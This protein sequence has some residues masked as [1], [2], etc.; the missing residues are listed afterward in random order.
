MRE[1]RCLIAI[2]TGACVGWLGG[3]AEI[4]LPPVTGELSGDFRSFDSATAPQLHWTSSLRGAGD[5]AGT[6]IV[7]ANIEGEGT[8]VRVVT[9]LTTTEQGSWQ[10]TEGALDLATWFP[11]ISERLGNPTKGLA[12]SGAVAV[13]GQGLIRAGQASGVVQV[14]L[15][16]GRLGNAEA[17]WTLEGVTLTGEFLFEGQGLTLKSLVPFQFSVAK[18][19]TKRFGAEN[20]RLRGLLK[21]DRTVAVSEAQIEIAGGEVKIDPATM[22]LSPFVLEAVLHIS[23]VGLQDIAA[24]IP[25]SFAAAQGRID[26]VVRLG[27]SSA[28][29]FRLGAGNLTLG[30]TEPAIVR[31]APAPGFLTR[32]MPK[33]FEPVPSWTGPLS[34]WLSTDNPVYSD[35]SAIELGRAS[36]RVESLAVQLTPDGDERGR[37]ATVRMAARPTQPNA[38][39]K[40]VNIDVNVAG[41]LDAILK[42]GLNRELSLKPR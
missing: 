4:K 39:V 18:I 29:G 11:V 5:A 37:T 15:G 41:P 36:L 33:R 16:D 31:L 7:A 14:T 40:V 2:A 13:T 32:S 19:T 42:L 20:L 21:E 25:Q 38:A 1:L 6:T 28:Q 10:I 17:G 27:W 3:A 12:A 34:K 35:M 30:T 23:N 24:L 22:V 8:R 26:G 9:S